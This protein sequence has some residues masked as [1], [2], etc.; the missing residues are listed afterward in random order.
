M[1]DSREVVGEQR[2]AEAT[3]AQSLVV[4]QI[5][6]DRPW[7]WLA[8]GWRDLWAYPAI[9]FAYGALPTGLGLA[10]AVALALFEFG[11]LVPVLAGGFTL[12]GPL[13]AVGLYEKSRLLA[14]GQTPTFALTLAKARSSALRLGLLAALLLFLYLVWLRI[15]FM[16]LALFLGTRGLPP[17]QEFTST[18]LFTPHGLGLLIVGT[19]VGGLLAAVGFAATAVSIPLLMHRHVDAISAIVT[20][21]QTVLTNPKPMALWAALIAG[22]TA[23]GIATLGAG[24]VVA[25]PLVGHATWHAYRDAIDSGP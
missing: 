15:A 16:L 17:A 5:A 9:S 6:F 1:T 3:R 22:F 14:E 4:R 8:A 11:A 18:L 24:L 20:S 21:I 23:L 25:F 12:I 13:L 2:V 10:I 7:E 19:A